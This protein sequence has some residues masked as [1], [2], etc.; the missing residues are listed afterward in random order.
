MG[1]TIVVGK[2]F[3]GTTIVVGKEFMGD[4]HCSG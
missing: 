4:Y 3:M 1:T 2:E